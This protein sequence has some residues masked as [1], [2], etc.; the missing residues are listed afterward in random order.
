MAHDRRALEKL[1]GLPASLAREAGQSAI[2]RLSGDFRA[3]RGVLFERAQ[4][5]PERVLERFG[6]SVHETVSAVTVSD[7][8]TVAD[9]SVVDDLFQRPA[10]LGARERRERP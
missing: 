8:A 4:R 10:A 7:V 2:A 9:Q 5:R 1:A 3:K 6:V